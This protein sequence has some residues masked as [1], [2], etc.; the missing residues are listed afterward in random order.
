MKPMVISKGKYKARFNFCFKNQAFS[1]L[2]CIVLDIKLCLGISPF[3]ET[4]PK[5]QEYMS[6]SSDCCGVG[7]GTA[8]MQNDRES[9]A[10]SL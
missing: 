6:A 4:T 1:Q 8:L 10:G 5:N 3:P 2:L 9:Q 7:K